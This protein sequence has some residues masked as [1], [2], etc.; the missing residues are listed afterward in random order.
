MV[1]QVLRVNR[2]TV[3]KLRPEPTGL[4][5]PNEQVSITAGSTYPLHSYAHSDINGSFNGHIK[6][7]LRD[8]NING[9]NTWFVSSLDAQVEANG[10]VVYP[11]EDQESIPVLWINQNTLFKRRPLDSTL[12]DASETVPV[13]RGQTYQ[14]HSYAFADSQGGFNNH[15][16]F[17]IRNPADFV[18]GLST[19]FV[20]TPHIFVTFDNNVVYPRESPNALI[21]RITENTV[22]KRRPL[23]ASD[24]PPNER[25]PARSGSEFVIGSYAYADAQGTFNR[26]IRFSFKYVKD[27]IFGFNTWY[28][29]DGHAQVE[30]AGTVLYP[31]PTPSAPTSPPPTSPPSPPQYQGQPFR[32]PGFT[33]TFYTDQPIIPNGNFTWGEATRNATR[34]PSTRD[35]VENIMALASALQPVRNRLGR[36]FQVNSWYRPPDVNAAVGGAQFSQHLTGRAVDVQVQGLTGRQVANAVMLSWPGG[37]GIYSNMPLVIHLDIGPRRT[38]GF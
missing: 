24:L 38:W 37:I 26:H 32:L 12:L 4:L 16:R 30:R 21:L 13:R 2:N 6:F 34:I 35:I 36:P 31:Q 22:F 10:T 33:S 27:N 28:I 9:L 11:H 5:Q 7:A 15:I 18:N 23:P 25:P 14:L 29:Y 3:F 1:E 17:A 20:F 19:W 8:R